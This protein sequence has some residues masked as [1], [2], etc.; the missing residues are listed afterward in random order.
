MGLVLT[1]VLVQASCRLSSPK[2]VGL[3]LLFM[4]PPQDRGRNLSP[5][6]R[7]LAVTPVGKVPD[8]EA[9]YLPLLWYFSWLWYFCW[10]FLGNKNIW[11]LV[12]GGF[13]EEG[14]PKAQV[15]P[16]LG[17][18]I[19][20]WWLTQKNKLQNMQTNWKRD[21]DEEHGDWEIKEA[22]DCKIQTEKA[23]RWFSL[24]MSFGCFVMWSS[25]NATT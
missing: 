14:G 22:E 25:C 11:C 10:P 4:S 21:K 1:S 20:F 2:P 13:L 15:R 7:R 16:F 9:A 12:W 18:C 3:Y 5:N 24:D 8:E 19:L 17:P 6:F 23:E